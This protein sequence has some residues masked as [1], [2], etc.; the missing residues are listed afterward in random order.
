MKDIFKPKSN[1]KIRPFDTTVNP[2]KR[3]SC[4]HIENSQLICRTNQLTGFYMMA[5]LA[6]NKLIHV[7]YIKFGNKSLTNLSPKI[8]NRLPTAI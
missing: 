8:W 6:F 1:V 7:S 4:H 5:T 3:Q 2:L